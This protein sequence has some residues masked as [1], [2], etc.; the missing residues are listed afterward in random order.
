M[1]RYTRL[2][3][4]PRFSA[5]PNITSPSPHQ[6]TYASPEPSA[7]L[8]HDGVQPTPPQP[9][10]QSDTFSRR[11]LCPSN[12][13]VLLPRFE[14]LRRAVV[15]QC[16]FSAAHLTRQCARDCACG[17]LE[18]FSPRT[19][20]TEARSRCESWRSGRRAGEPDDIVQ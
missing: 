15:R 17:L 3:P 13:S 1:G 4:V 9:H 14:T 10:S 19:G 8:S 20:T 16:C 5:L 7:H 6:S 18:P 12:F 2:R 11:S